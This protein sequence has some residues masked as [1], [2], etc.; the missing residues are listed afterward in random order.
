MTSLLPRLVVAGGRRCSDLGPWFRGRTKL[1]DRVLDG[2][3]LTCRKQSA[4]GARLTLTATVTATVT[5]TP[6]N[7]GDT[8]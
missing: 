1:D 7:S 6:L 5:A 4:P 8:R 2:P 3:I